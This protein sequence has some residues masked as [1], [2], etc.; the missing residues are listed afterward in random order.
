MVVS[1][2]EVVKLWKGSYR[3]WKYKC[4]WYVRLHSHV[5]PSGLIKACRGSGNQQSGDD[6]ENVCGNECTVESGQDWWTQKRRKV[7]G[8]TMQRGIRRSLISDHLQC[9]PSFCLGTSE[10]Q[11]TFDN[12]DSCVHTVTLCLGD[13]S[14]G[15][16]MGP[17]NLSFNY[18]ETH[19]PVPRPQREFY[20]GH[21]AYI[22]SQF[23]LIISFQFGEYIYPGHF[24]DKQQSNSILYWHSLIVF[25]YFAWG[26]FMFIIWW[27]ANWA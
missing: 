27:Q 6:G 16:P 12:S 14:L 20:K 11:L 21:V 22:V 5:A 10:M 8:L 4:P 1:S 18:S 25:H 19:P 15:G 26:L 2:R 23:I 24:T 17:L 3:D 13:L 9:W 7:R